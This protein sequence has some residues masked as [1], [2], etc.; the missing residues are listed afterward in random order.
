MFDSGVGGLTVARAVIDQL[1]AERVVYVGDTAHSPYG[2]LP[3][4]EIR[5][6]TLAIGDELMERGVKALVVACNSASASCLPD[7]RERYPVPVV[8]VVRPAVRRAVAATRNGRIG[9]IGTVATITSGAYQDS[10]AAARDAEITAV[11][12]PRFV[13]FVERGMTSGRQVLGLAQSYLE[14]LQRAGVDTV[15]L[16]CTHYPLLTGVLQIVLGPEVT[17]VSSAD[18]TAKD[19]VR[20]LMAA[21]LLRDP[22]G[23]APGP[24]EFLATGDPE[25]FA[26]LGRRFLGPE[27]RRVS[28]LGA[29]VRAG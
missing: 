17:L 1:P 10:F 11:A 26:R 9:V 3:I 25:P 2:P 24:H 16:G 15:V 5:R 8:E 23:P 21:D 19:L 6:H 22:E 4:A 13:D 20:V 29:A 18:E 12:C 27:I 28:P 7:I 14:P